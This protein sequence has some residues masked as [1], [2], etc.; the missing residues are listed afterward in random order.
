MLCP[1]AR[2]RQHPE[3]MTGYYMRLLEGEP[4]QQH[5]T[6]CEKH[7]AEVG[8]YNILLTGAAFF[9][10]DLL[11]KVSGSQN[12][13]YMC[14][15]LSPYCSIYFSFDG[16][17][18]AC[19]D[20]TSSTDINQTINTSLLFQSNV[21]CCILCHGPFLISKKGFTS[22]GFL[23]RNKFFSNERKVV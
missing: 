19:F 12:K 17:L 16:Q 15:T 18:N 20:L 10:K 9:D 6:Y 23:G 11:F 4:P 2:W 14:V 7:T 8:R 21:R 1:P 22:L 13:P 5:C 3:R